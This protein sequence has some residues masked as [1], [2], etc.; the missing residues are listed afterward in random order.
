MVRL[1]RYRQVFEAHRKSFRE[2]GYSENESSALPQAIV[3]ARLPELRTL[4]QWVCY[5]IVERKGKLTKVPYQPNGVEADVTNPKTWSSFAAVFATKG[6][7]GVSFVLT[8][9]AGYIG[10]DLDKYRDRRLGE[11]ESWA[12]AIIE[13]MD[14]YTELSQS[15]L[16]ASPRHP[17]FFGEVRDG[18]ISGS[19]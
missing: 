16:R 17:V 3:A 14:S 7:D 10:I 19:P 9:E 12:R 8:Y 1:G 4:D 18:K 11:P 13:E 5:R 6:Y 2:N 15:G